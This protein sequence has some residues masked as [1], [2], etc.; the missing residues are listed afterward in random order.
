MSKQQVRYKQIGIRFTQEE[1]RILK[2][3]QAA[4]KHLPDVLPEM[5]NKKAIEKYARMFLE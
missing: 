5:Q 2:R 4:L 3:V 1:I